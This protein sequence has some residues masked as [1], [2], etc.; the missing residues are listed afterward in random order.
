METKYIFC[1]IVGGGMSGVSLAQAFLRKSVLK[2]DEFIILD[3]NA[4]Y[5]GVWESN[6]YPGVACDIPSHAYVMRYSLNPDWTMKYSEGK[7]IQQYYAGIADRSNLR[8]LTYFHTLV[9]S[10]TWNESAALWEILVENSETKKRV[11]WKANVL[12]NCGGS[13]YRAKYA[14]IP[15]IENFKG[16]QWHT[17]AWPKDADLTGKTVAILGT[18]PS[19][20]Q[21]APSIQ[22]IVKKLYMYQ[23]SSGHVLPRNN[24]QQ[25]MWKRLLF[26][27]CWPILWLYH[28]WFCISAEFTKPMFI[29]GTKQNIEIGNQALAFLDEQIKDPVLKEKLRP[30]VAF[31]CKRPLFLD[32]WYPMFTKPNV[33]LIT[34]KPI[35]FT[36]K[37]LVSKHPD[38]ITEEERGEMPVG[39]YQR[40]TTVTDDEV[41][42]EFDVLIWGTGFDMNN[43]GGH[44]DIFGLNNVKLSKLW[45]DFPRAYW[46]VA[47]SGFPNYFLIQGP[48]SGNYW[49][50]GPTVTE[51]QVN[52]HCKMIKRIKNECKNGKYALHPDYKVQKEY[53]DWLFENQGT[54]AFLAPECATYHKSPSGATPMHN[55]HRMP[56][57]W[58]KLRSPDMK[59]FKE[60]RLPMGKDI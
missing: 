7:E 50:S 38:K 47:V 40:P 37:G 11:L 49:A 15:G 28:V 8:Q 31:G 56:T 30:K 29:K 6:T 43:W 51:F 24:H 16:Q 27:Y 44:F 42:R 17:T 9:I 45:G 5:G 14:S 59:E 20:A 32:N 60:I 1:A 36:E 3:K 58:W 23:R 54:P 26:R 25:P 19:A 52:Y 46:G 22:P 12:Y 39:S 21:V 13:F 4:D 57:T 35:K 53:T 34:E 33:E 55:H 10:A 2:R 18:G 41:E 48:N